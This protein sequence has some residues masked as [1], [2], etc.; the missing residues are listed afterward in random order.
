MFL[1]NSA[2]RRIFVPADAVPRLEHR[3]VGLS[4]PL[5][6]RTTDRLFAHRWAIGSKLANR[7]T[8]YVGVKLSGLTSGR[9]KKS[10][11]AAVVK[12][13]ADQPTMTLLRDNAVGTYE[14]SAT[15]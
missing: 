2:L 10:P 8:G 1:K 9:L 15:G 7:T 11:Q 4:G 13:G 6:K 3:S 14:S 12:S 5:R